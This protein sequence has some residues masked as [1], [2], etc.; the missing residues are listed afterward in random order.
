MKKLK[1][2][3]PISEKKLKPREKE[4]YVNGKEFKEEI[5]E[6]YKTNI[7]TDKLADCIMKIAHGLSYAP[8]FINYCVSSSYEALTQRGWLKYDEITLE[9]KVM[10]YDLNKK[11]L[12]WGDIKNINIINNYEGIMH[13]LLWDK[14][15]NSFTTPNHK[16]IVKDC[17][18]KEIILKEV[19]HLQKYDQVL[20]EP[21]LFA[22]VAD[23]THETTFY[24]GIVWCLETEYG[25]FVCRNGGYTH[26]T[27]NSYKPDM[28]GDAIL[29]MYTALKNHK[30]KVDSE[31]NPFSYM[32]TVSFHAFIN[33]IKK[34]KKHH[35]TI[36]E[37]KERIYTDAMKEENV[38]IDPTHEEQDF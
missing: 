26:I 36:N 21:N 38:Y 33:R 37:Y 18:S 4:Y 17:I 29:K 11:L 22:Q 30:F 31:F 28:V 15:I 8:N 2:Q 23:M 12:V 6:Y 25:N 10:S 1:T 35:D 16:L 32:T 13:S 20:I 3:K 14:V 7:V 34:E 27:G 9:D 5:R 24:K 19:Q